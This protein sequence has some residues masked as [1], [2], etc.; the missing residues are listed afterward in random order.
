VGLLVGNPELSDP[1]DPLDPELDILCV[2][3]FDD[4]GVSV[5]V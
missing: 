3:E 1:E 2:G 4:D 5:V